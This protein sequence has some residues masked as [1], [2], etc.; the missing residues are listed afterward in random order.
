MNKKNKALGILLGAIL[1]V[2]FATSALT[3]ADL[4]AQVR[5][6]LAR[7]AV[8]QSAQVSGGVS[9]SM[10]TSIEPAMP[11]KAH[12][13]CG[14]LH[15]NLVRGAQGDD[16]RGLQEFLTSEGYLSASA[17]GFFGPMTAQALA[18]WQAKEGVQSVGSLGPIT[19]ER[20]KMRCG[21]MGN[22]YGFRV[23]PQVG[24]APLTVTAY[25]NVGGFTLY[26]YFVDFGDGSA[27]ESIACSA[28]ADVCIQPGAVQHTYSQDGSYTVALY[29][30]HPGGC[31]V[32]ADPR[33]LGM[34][35]Q[36]I[37]IAK[38]SVRVGSGPVAC[39]M[40]YNPVCGAK[41][42]TCI[43]TPCNPVQQ[44]YSNRCM[45][46]ADGATY[47]H[48]GA[49]GATSSGG[50]PVVSQ[51]AGPVSLG[52]NEVGTWNI[53]A[54]DPEN[55]RL[56]Y[57]IIWGDEWTRSTAAPSS[58]AEASIVQQTTITH[59]Y[60]NP[61]NYVVQLTVTDQ[62]GK[63]AQASAS[64]Q[65]QQSVCTAQYEPVCGRPQGCANTCPPG[66]YC[67]MMCRLHDPVTYSNRCQLNNANAS[68]L[69]AGACTG[70]E[71]Y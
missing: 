21:G 55:G 5:D 20:I 13:I 24:N 37:V 71:T 8:M 70:Q 57:S 33:C 34:P 49:C 56:T 66:M 1:V 60:S 39:T 4:Q 11:L 15:R 64:V 16:V 42:V 67:T 51:F 31:G 68:F 35:A 48:Q 47:V 18:Q 19:R 6:L 7:I 28:P 62:S 52:V 10:P 27:R 40:E 30:T 43:T 17:T 14:I 53:S 69:H 58:G 50:A 12:R 45:M 54:S 44:T 61:G 25:A 65:V 59:A 46:T 32:N 41:P 26:R 9:A 22:E 3:V 63:S 38:E 2:P 29:R 23:T 36:E